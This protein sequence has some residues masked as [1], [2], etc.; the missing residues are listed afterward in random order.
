M[1]CTLMTVSGSGQFPGGVLTTGLL[2]VCVRKR[3]I[4]TGPFTGQCVCM[5]M[6]SLCACR[7]AFINAIVYNTFKSGVCGSSCI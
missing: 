5:L 7:S 3:H 1:V 4:L 2:A 6:M